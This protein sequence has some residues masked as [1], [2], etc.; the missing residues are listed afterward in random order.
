MCS[1]QL[2]F[3][4]ILF[5][6]LGIIQI[7]GSTSYQLDGKVMAHK[8]ENNEVEVFDITTFLWHFRCWAILSRPFTN[9]LNLLKIIIKWQYP[10]VTFSIWITISLLSSV[11]PTGYS[12]IILFAF[13]I[14]GCCLGMLHHHTQIF[15]KLFPDQEM[16]ANALQTYLQRSWGEE[17]KILDEY[18]KVLQ[19]LDKTIE[20]LNFYLE[21]FYSV[22]KW[23]KPIVSISCVVA[24]GFSAVTL[25]VADLSVFIF[26][27]NNAVLLGYGLYSK[28]KASRA[29]KGLSPILQSASPLNSS[30][31][32]S[33]LDRSSEK[34]ECDM[35]D[36]ELNE[37]VNNESTAMNIMKANVVEGNNSNVIQKI[38]DL[39][40]RH[41]PTLSSGI[42]AGCHSS[43]MAILKRKYM[44]CNCGNQFCWR[45]CNV[46]VPKSLLGV[47][48]P[49]TKN[50]TVLVCT[51]CHQQLHEKSN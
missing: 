41:Q 17:Q 33:V 8:M 26:I 40:R 13:L 4:S 21:L 32:C 31:T 45:C 10:A 44:C 3:V 6:L 16:E 35:E 38:M 18:R 39:R 42:C 20:N 12:V 47:T 29:I 51:Q 30:E 27:I 25:L 23:E 28:I 46:K 43:L 9:F 2:F 7:P 11:I 19:K 50:D 15:I 22:L 24:V 34:E 1:R 14:I 49:S 48:A 5:I 36:S 37:D